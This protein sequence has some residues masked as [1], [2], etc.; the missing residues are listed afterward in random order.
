LNRFGLLVACL[1]PPS[2]DADDSYSPSKQ[3]ED[4]SWL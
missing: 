1:L 2:S 3:D 4:A